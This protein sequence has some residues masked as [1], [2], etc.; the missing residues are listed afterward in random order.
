M[1]YFI[2]WLFDWLI[3]WSE[4]VRASRIFTQLNIHWYGELDDDESI[5]W[6]IGW[7][8]IDWFVDWSIDWSEGERASKIFTQLDING[9]GELDEDEFCKVGTFQA[10]GGRVQVQQ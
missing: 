5:D 8:T 3:D 6:F 2:D 9:D 10:L 4:G 7:W 1:D